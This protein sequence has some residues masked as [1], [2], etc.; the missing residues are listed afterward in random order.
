MQQIQKLS[1]VSKGYYEDNYIQYFIPDPRRQL[2]PMNMGYHLRAMA[3][4][5]SAKKFYSMFGPNSQVVQLGCGYD[6]L[7]F[8]LRD[9]K[10]IFS[11]WI[12]LDLNHIVQR[13]SRVISAGHF[14][15][16]TNYA[17]VEA[18]LENF[19]NFKGVLEKKWF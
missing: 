5:L 6:T 12:D 15:P 10:I 13:K 2:P 1:A 9:E 19:A 4:Y 11:K 3:I 18:D 7:F 14:Q 8:R 17:L 16:L